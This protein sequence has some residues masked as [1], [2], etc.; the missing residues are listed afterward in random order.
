M[1]L[2][3]VRRLRESLRKSTT[4]PARI[5]PPTIR[6]RFAATNIPKGRI[7]MA[8]ISSSSN[9]AG[10]KARQ[11][12]GP[13]KGSSRTDTRHLSRACITSKARRADTSTT[14]DAGPGPGLLEA[15]VQRCSR[16]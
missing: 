13:L 8:T 1:T 15:A 10:I 6:W 5:I 2:R 3:A 9:K 7:P 12:R 4:M 14:E 16:P 11:V